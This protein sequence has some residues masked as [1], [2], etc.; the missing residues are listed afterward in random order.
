MIRMLLTVQICKQ[1]MAKVGHWHLIFWLG[2]GG[3]VFLGNKILALDMPE[4]FKL[5]QK[6]DK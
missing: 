4:K 2:G 6:W 1:V 5:A 3:C